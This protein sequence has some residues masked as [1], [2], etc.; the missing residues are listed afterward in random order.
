MS[1]C[2]TVDPPPPPVA[3]TTREEGYEMAREIGANRTL[4][5][6]LQQ[7]NAQLTR[8]VCSLMY[9]LAGISVRRDPA[10]GRNRLVITDVPSRPA[11]GC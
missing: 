4:I 3:V 5:S 2:Q 7:Q 1:G 11:G 6:Q 10:T 8:Q 9:Q